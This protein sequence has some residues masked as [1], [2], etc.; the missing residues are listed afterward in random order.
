[1]LLIGLA[2]L[3]AVA[4]LL[5]GLLLRRRWYLD[6]PVSPHGLTQVLLAMLLGGGLGSVVALMQ[7]PGVGTVLAFVFA[8]AGVIVSW[9]DM[10][11]HLIPNW[12]TRPL[13]IGLLGI[14]AVEALVLGQW[15]RFFGALLGG[16]VAFGVLF[17]LAMV[18][19]LGLGDVKL[20]ASIGV[21]LGYVGWLT[22]MQ[23]LILS[24]VFGAFVAVILL[25]CGRTGNS[26]LPLGPALVL[27]P[28]AALHLPM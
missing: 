23:G 13:V 10:D 3:G 19:S 1:M 17:L 20:G 16:V 9:I 21:L 8:C 27:G 4:G 5:G 7:L 25:L 28:L 12:L 2:A 15:D 22:L 24:F 14:I 26:Y 6:V 18:S 11:A